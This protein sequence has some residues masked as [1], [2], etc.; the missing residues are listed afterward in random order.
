MN[1][2]SP[3]QQMDRRHN[4]VVHIVNPVSPACQRFDNSFLRSF[5]FC[6]DFEYGRKATQYTVL[7][8]YIVSVLCGLSGHLL[9]YTIPWCPG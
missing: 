2:Y 6:S 1:D 8:C 4:D 3:L 7:Y 5:I 9:V